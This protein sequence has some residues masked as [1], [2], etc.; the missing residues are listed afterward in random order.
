MDTQNVV[1]PYSGILF[2]HKK[3]PSATTLV[4]SENII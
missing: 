2:C 3:E 4:N 1:Y